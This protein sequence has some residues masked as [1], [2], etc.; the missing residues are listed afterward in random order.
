MILT[1]RALGW[2]I[3]GAT[4]LCEPDLDRAG[5]TARS[6]LP[7]GLPPVMVDV[8]QVEQVLV[9]LL[10]NSIEAI[11]ESGNPARS[12][13]IEAKLAG[14][15][16]VEV[17][18]ADWGP[19]LLTRAHRESSSGFQETRWSRYRVVA[20]QIDHRGPWRST[21]LEARSEGGLVR[22]TLPVAKDDV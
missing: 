1:G 19:R 11:G 20:V 16:F 15:E 18:V 13:V 6:V 3:K 12:I 8:L 14:N 2:I 7:T 17:I 21:S 4:T 5:V 9:N 10:R 22:F